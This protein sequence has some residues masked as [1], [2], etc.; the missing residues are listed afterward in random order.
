MH[1]TIA[2]FIVI[3]IYLLHRYPHSSD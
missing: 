1:V 2:H 3:F